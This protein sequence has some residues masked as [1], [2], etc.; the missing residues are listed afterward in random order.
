ME[1]NNIT[2]QDLMSLDDEYIMQAESDREIDVHDIG[3][4]EL[5]ERDE[6]ID[7]AFKNQALARRR[8]E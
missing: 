4:I 7:P 1:K 2:T 8:E 3:F 6:L 5:A